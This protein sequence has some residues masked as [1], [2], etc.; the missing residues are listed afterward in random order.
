MS[1]RVDRLQCRFYRRQH[2]MLAEHDIALS[3]CPTVRHA[4]VRDVAHR[5]IAAVE[6]R[7]FSARGKG[8]WCRPSDRQHPSFHPYNKA[9]INDTVTEVHNATILTSYDV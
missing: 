1:F 2:V 8:P 9:Y 3:L 4:Y 5:R 7:G 6:A